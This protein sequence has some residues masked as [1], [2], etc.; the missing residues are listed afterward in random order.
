MGASDRYSLGTCPPAVE[1]SR[2]FRAQVAEKMAMLPEN[3][4]T[5][6]MMLDDAVMRA[7]SRACTEVFASQDH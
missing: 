5:A 3:A 2:E 6:E 7:Q 1:Y 4:A